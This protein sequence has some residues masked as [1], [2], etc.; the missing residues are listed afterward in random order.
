[1]THQDLGAE[2]IAA[3]ADLQEEIALA[4]VQQRLEAGGDPLL[5][6]KDCEEG[7]RQ[8]GLRY[9]RRDYFLAGLIMAGVIWVTHDAWRFWKLSR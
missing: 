5:M 3:I 2:L 1:M 4:L 6:I 9:E 8:V 7:L